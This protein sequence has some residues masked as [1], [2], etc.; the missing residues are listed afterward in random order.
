MQPG[1]LLVVRLNNRPGIGRL[2]EADSTRVR[3]AIGRNREARLPLARVLLNTGVRA[4][5]HE[6]VETLTGDA[7]SV[8][9]L[10]DLTDLWDIVCDDGVVMD[11]EGMAELYWSGEPTPA[12]RVGLLFHLHRDD[13]RF[14]ETNGEYAPRSREEVK[15]LEARRER[16]ARHG[17][18][19]LALAASLASGAPP[20]TVTSH[21]SHLL[22]QLRGLAVF[23]DDYAAAAAAKKYLQ[24]IADNP[25]DPQRTAFQTLV[26]AGRLPP[27][28]FLALEAAGIPIEFS[29]DVLAEAETIDTAAESEHP[30]RHDLTHLDVITIDD[31]DT[32]DRDDG[33]SIERVQVEVDGVQTPAFQVGVHI[34]DA[35]AIV[36]AGTGLDREADRRMATLYLPERNIWML[37]RSIAGDVGSLTAGEPRLAV[38]LLATVTQGGE[39]VDWEVTP[40][41]IESRAAMSYEDVDDRLQDDAAPMHRPLSDLDT[42][43]RKLKEK[44]ESTG[45]PNLDRDELSVKVSHTGE[46]KVDVIH[47]SHP[48]RS[49]VAEYMIFY[50]SLMAQFCKRNELPAPY[51]AQKAPDI[52]DIISQTPEGL[53]RWYLTVRKMG[54]ASI[55]TEPQPHAGLGVPAYVQASSPLRRYPDLV[56]QRQISH[57]LQTDESYYTEE[58]I[59]S[60]AQR[61]DLQI[62]ELSRLEFERQK[63]WFLKYLDAERRKLEKAGDESIHE[64]YVLENQP[65]RAGVMDLVRYPFRVRAA[66]VSAVKPGEVV[67]LRLHGVDLWRRVGQ[68]VVAAP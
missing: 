24:T 9:S 54:P 31:E 8:A 38:S 51:R 45:T 37:P 29:E 3:V 12:Q 44:R 20:D 41:T 68:F 49:M 33:L 2:V 61:A 64:A 13:L 23:G 27:D 56:V 6:D 59:S 57:F 55:S 52:G 32:Q 50:N 14:T 65:N 21:Q 19:A 43:A 18:E 47:R 22:D 11:L 66:L 67:K 1:D 16:A 7:E 30:R 4:S 26:K 46:I 35:G 40:S 48:A 5:G 17:A 25:G 63:Y 42:L 60:V 58:E 62:R 39:V 34:A 10:V 53:L 28:A 15:Q 36:K